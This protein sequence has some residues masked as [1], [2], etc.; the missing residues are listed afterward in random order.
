MDQLHVGNG[1]KVVTKM[2]L[3]EMLLVRSFEDKTKKFF[4]TCVD[5]SGEG[6]PGLPALDEPLAAA[7]VY[8][9]EGKDLI[10]VSTRGISIYNFTTRLT[11]LLREIDWGV[12]DVN[13]IWLSPDVSAIFYL[14]NKMSPTLHEVSAQSRKKHQQTSTDIKMEASLYACSLSA[15][16]PLLIV[17]F[18]E[19]ISFAD[20]DWEKNILIASAGTRGLIAA[21]LTDGKISTLRTTKTHLGVSMA[22][23]NRVISW[24]VSGSEPIEEIAPDVQKRS[25]TNSG[26]FPTFSSNG[27]MAFIKKTNELWLRGQDGDVEMVLTLQSAQSTEVDAATWCSCGA[28]FALNLE[29]VS[30][31]GVMSRILT[32]ANISDKELL[33]APKLS[34]SNARVWIPGTAVV[35]KGGA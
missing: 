7:P 24:S 21:N 16:E 19:P 11:R 8:A 15:D 14:Q 4:W 5:G 26:R 6:S 1:W 3:D 28:H 20:I 23:R 9:A 25:L 33:L 10:Y 34:A 32:V 27:A 30:A 22:P 2:D 31:S 13:K 17:E 35:G 12:Y 29:T 18:R